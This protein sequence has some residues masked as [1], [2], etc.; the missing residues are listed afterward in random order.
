MRVTRAAE[1][2]VHLYSDAA[3]AGNEGTPHAPERETENRGAVKEYV[4]M[5][6]NVH[7]HVHG[8]TR[9]SFANATRLSAVFVISSAILSPQRMKHLNVKREV[10][11]SPKNSGGAH[12]ALSVKMVNRSREKTPAAYRK[13]RLPTFHRNTG[14]CQHK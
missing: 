2:R 4:E 1:N 3:R 9:S 10:V 7:L 13:R 6:N 12:D 14:A 5:P 11:L 8:C